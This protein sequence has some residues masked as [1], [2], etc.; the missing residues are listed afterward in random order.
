MRSPSAKKNITS[1]TILKSRKEKQDGY[2]KNTDSD[3]EI[4][5]MTDWALQNGKQ[6]LLSK[7]L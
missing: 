7:L 3:E 4:E 5:K 1:S 6:I 2:V